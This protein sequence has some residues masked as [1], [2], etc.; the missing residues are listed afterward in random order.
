MKNRTSILM[1]ALT[2]MLGGIIACGN[3]SETSKE[4]KATGPETEV[5]NLYLEL[6]EALVATDA[7][8]AKQ[9]AEALM[10][11]AETLTDESA[12]TEIV[13]AATAIA[14]AA[15]IKAQRA[16]LDP[17][18]NAVY[19]VARSTDMSMPLYYMHCPMAN[20]GNGGYW[21]SVSKEVKNPYFGDKMLKCGS[22]KEEL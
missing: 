13:T 10:Q 2:I 15:D 3:S 16:Q 20:Q 22:V 5:V 1:L 19:K 18:T 21:I 12:K 6:K 9:A 11:K 4:V 14:N 8:K 17:L 7:A